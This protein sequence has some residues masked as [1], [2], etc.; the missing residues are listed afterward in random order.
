[1]TTVRSNVCKI[2][3]YIGVWSIRLREMYKGKSPVPL[4]LPGNKT[5]ELKGLIAIKKIEKNPLK[6]LNLKVLL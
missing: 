5:Y 1:M 2:I 4:L 6:I 3:N